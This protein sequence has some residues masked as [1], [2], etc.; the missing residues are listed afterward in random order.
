MPKTGETATTTD[1]PIE[2]DELSG[3]E[4]DAFTNI[5]DSTGNL[6][7]N[8]DRH[9]E[10][11]EWM[12]IDRDD[13]GTVPILLDVGSTDSAPFDADPDLAGSGLRRV[14]NVF[15]SKISTAVPTDGLHELSRTNLTRG[16]ATSQGSTS[17]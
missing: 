12:W 4:I 13:D 16:I 3:L 14:G 6:M 15:E 8:D 7:S 5:G 1:H 10:P 9:A 17:E 2:R 11:R